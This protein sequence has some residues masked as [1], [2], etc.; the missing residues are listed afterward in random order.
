MRGRPGRRL[1]VML[2]QRHLARP[3]MPLTRAD[4]EADLLRR[5]YE[6]HHPGLA[7]MPRETVLARLRG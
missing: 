5:N 4:L 1:A 6:R 7:L 3:A 2:D